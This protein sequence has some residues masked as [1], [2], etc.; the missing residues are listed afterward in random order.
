MLMVYGG[1]TGGP[2]SGKG[3]QCEMIAKEFSQISSAEAISPKLFHVSMGDLLRQELRMH[4]KGRAPS[5][6]GAM[7]EDVF[8][9]G[10]ILPGY[11]SVDIL[12]RVHSSPLCPSSST[13]SVQEL[14]RLNE[15]DQSPLFLLDGF[16]RSFHYSC[17]VW[18]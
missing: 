10:T 14:V 15:A 16:P 8:A 3:T 11:V 9:K 7:I 2:G 18:S 13:R 4:K 12:N 1:V 5:P 17:A 6:Y